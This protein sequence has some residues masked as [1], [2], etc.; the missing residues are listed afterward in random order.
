MFYLGSRVIVGL[1]LGDIAR[2]RALEPDVVIPRRRW[3][4]SLA[5]LRGF[6]ARGRWEE[7]RLPVLDTHYND[8]PSL[9]PTPATPDPH[10]FRTPQ[11]DPDA[12]GSLRIFHRQARP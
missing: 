7:E 2:E 3:P 10:R 8:M 4:R 1:A 9:T 12:P 6:L 11:S 5:E